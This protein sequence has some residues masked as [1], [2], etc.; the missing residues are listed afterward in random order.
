MKN[1]TKGIVLAILAAM[2]S[3]IA[4]PANKLF[5]VNLDP[6]VF[7]AIRAVIIGVIFLALSLYQSKTSHK[8]FKEVPWKYLLSI[9]IIGG[10]FAFILYF[11][12]LSLTTAGRAA[13]RPA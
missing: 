8:K 10:A 7:T 4:I 11:N 9:A 13:S 5:I 6:T 1:E 2:V 3:G 12:G